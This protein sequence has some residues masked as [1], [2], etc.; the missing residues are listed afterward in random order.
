MAL[1]LNLIGVPYP[2]INEDHVHALAGHVRAFATNLTNT[3]ESASGT[4]KDMGSV[5]SGYSYEALVR[6]WAQLSKSHMAELDA[7]CKVVGGALDIAADVIKAVKVATLAELAALAASYTAALA[8]TFATGGAAAVVEQL[9]TAAARKL[10]EAMEQML[11]GYLI[12]EVM[13]KAI[14]PLEHVID[15]LIHGVL[16]DATADL[17]GLDPN[18]PLYIDPEAVTHY[19]DVLD[20]HA[21]DILQHARDFANQ[22]ASLD[23]KTVGGTPPPGDLVTAPTVAQTPPGPPEADTP[24]RSSDVPVQPSPRAHIGPWDTARRTGLPSAPAHASDAG[25]G[26]ALTP[27]SHDAPG[28]APASHHEA[29]HALHE[30]NAGAANQ[31]QAATATPQA[32]TDRPPALGDQTETP[33]ARPQATASHPSASETPSRPGAE[34]ATPDPARTG[35]APRVPDASTPLPGVTGTGG[36]PAGDHAAR[37][38]TQDA[39]DTA[40]GPTDSGSILDAAAPAAATAAPD[41]GPDAGDSP[42]APELPAAQQKPTRRRSRRPGEAGSGAPWSRVRKTST[43]RGTPWKKAPRKTTRITPPPTGDKRS[44]TPWTGTGDT[45]E[46]PKVFAPEAEAAPRPPQQRTTS[47]TPAADADPNVANRSPNLDPPAP[48]QPSRDKPP[49][50]VAPQSDVIPGTHP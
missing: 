2:D 49:T 25:P 28:R 37:F 36:A 22:V 34:H 29:A 48:S 46:P 8:A 14:A 11:L 40:T 24:V 47:P 9:I 39:A 1:F 20:Q 18:A 50:V 3:H 27:G 23:F 41:P 19:A 32:R 17:L 42:G 35:V 6:S 33:G 16:Y 13:G 5:Y 43:G 10:C 4:I 7:A 31:P 45:A 15:R 12:S 44:K 38:D 21:D 26:R 30:P